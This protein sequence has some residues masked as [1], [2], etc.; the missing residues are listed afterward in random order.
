[1]EWIDYREKLGISFW[2]EKKASFFIAQLLNS[3]DDF[4]EDRIY[5]KDFYEIIDFDAVSEEEYHSLDR[6]CQ[7]LDRV[8]NEHTPLIILPAFF[9]HGQS[10]PIQQQHIDH[11]CC[12]AQ[13]QCQQK[14]RI[15]V[16]VRNLA[17]SV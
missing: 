9:L 6:R 4:F 1:M 5:S 11:L 14:S 3:L 12:F 7:G 16:E 8:V 2:D 10:C 13:V 17:A 15:H